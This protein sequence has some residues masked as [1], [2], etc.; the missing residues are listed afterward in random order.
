MQTTACAE[1][2]LEIFDVN[3]TVLILIRMNGSVPNLLVGLVYIW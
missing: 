3:L 1:S 2:Y